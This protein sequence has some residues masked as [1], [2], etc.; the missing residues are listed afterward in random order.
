MSPV[1]S[2][3]SRLLGHALLFGSILL[4]VAAHLLLK[5]G[6]DGV[7]TR[8]ESW[9][10]L[11][12]TGAGLGVYAAGTAC[13]LACLTHLDLS[14]A[15]PYTGLNYVLILLGSWLAFEDTPSPDRLAGVALI[16]AGTLLLP[17]SRGGL[18]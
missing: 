8:P 6:V 12:W 10:S 15:Y 7:A 4:G 11:L 2:D 13:W 3:R 5:H 16:C 14:Y 17:A 18:S 9:A 1:T